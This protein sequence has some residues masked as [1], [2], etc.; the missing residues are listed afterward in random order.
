MSAIPLGLAP[1]ALAEDKATLEQTFGSVRLWNGRLFVLDAIARD[2]DIAGEVAARARTRGR[3]ARVACASATASA[4]RTSGRSGRPTSPGTY[5]PGSA[6]APR[7]GS[8]LARF[9]ALT[10]GR[11]LKTHVPY[12]SK[13]GRCGAQHSSRPT[14]LHARVDPHRGH[15]WRCGR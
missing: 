15:T 14:S 11:G 12:G 2:R 4:Q 5:G 6:P 10:P 13:P 8:R 3:L 7:L 1:R 9:A